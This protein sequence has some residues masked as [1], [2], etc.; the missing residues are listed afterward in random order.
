MTWDLCYLLDI[1]FPFLYGQVADYAID[2]ITFM[3]KFR[4]FLSFTIQIYCH[5][6]SGSEVYSYIY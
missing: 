2:E 6:T 1:L 4:L 3:Y 5:S